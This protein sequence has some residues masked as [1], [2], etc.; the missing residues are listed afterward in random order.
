MLFL[1]QTT[2]VKIP[3]PKN[4]DP[5]RKFVGLMVSIPSQT[6]IGLLDN[7]GSLG[8]TNG[9]L[10]IM[11]HELLGIPQASRPSKFVLF[12]GGLWCTRAKS[13]QSTSADQH[14]QHVPSAGNGHPW[15]K[16]KL[17]FSMGHNTPSHWE[18]LTPSPP[19]KEPVPGVCS[20]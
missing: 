3:S 8:Y 14:V 18:F 13:N 9:S 19:K 6:V 2:Q 11:N 17:L 4:P 12:L 7:T 16:E 1:F 20:R 15:K 10:G 5:S